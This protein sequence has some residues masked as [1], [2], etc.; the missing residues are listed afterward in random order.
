MGQTELLGAWI[1]AT[2]NITA[3]IG[4]TEEVRQ[5]SRRTE[6]IIILGNGLQAIGNS[7]QIA[8]PVDEVL[9]KLGSELQVVG[10]LSIIGGV[11]LN[12]REERLENEALIVIGDSF[13]SIGAGLEVIN[14]LR[15]VDT[16]QPILLEIV[17]NSLQS[18]GAFIQAVSGAY[19]LG[20][21]EDRPFDGIF[22]VVGSWIQATGAVI[23]AV[24]ETIRPSP[25][26]H[27]DDEEEKKE[28]EEKEEESDCSFFNY[29][30]H[31]F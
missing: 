26:N 23:E 16:N 10:N 19:E 25:S 1:T 14:D 3:S 22:G 7:L 5:P 11:L 6:D 9:E 20:I 12:R 13:Q 30:P 4:V 28:E 24:K 8:G 15:N 31:Y 29:P 2:G 27:H 18:L 21:G 17:G